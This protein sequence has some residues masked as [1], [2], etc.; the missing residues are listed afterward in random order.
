VKPK[1]KSSSAWMARHLA[2]PYVK[3]ATAAGY[4][5][6]AAFKLLEIQKRDHLFKP[7]MVVVDLGAAPGSFSQVVA[8]LIGK[9]GRIY[10][11]DILEMKPLPHVDF[12]HG[13]F[14]ASEVES[15]LC[16]KIGELHGV[17]VV[18]SDLAPNIT[19]IASV[20]QPR[21]LALNE[22]A[23]EFARKMLKPNGTLLVKLFQGVGSDAYKQTLQQAFSRVM[24]RKPQASRQES[25]EVYLLAQ[26]FKE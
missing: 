1:T 16:A 19:G 8:K 25:R 17:D 4:R 14:L 11:I 6:R 5:S 2:D 10:A 13:D 18:I 20:D 24:V 12:I 9:H 7:G 23:L 15:A 26:G 3:E 22:A 21:A